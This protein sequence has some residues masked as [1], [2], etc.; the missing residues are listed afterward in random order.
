VEKVR[1]HSPVR[2][3]IRLNLGDCHTILAVHAERHLEH[4]RRRR[5]HGI[6]R[7]GV[8]RHDGRPLA[9]AKVTETVLRDPHDSMTHAVDP[10]A[11]NPFARLQARDYSPM[12]RQRQYQWLLVVVSTSTFH[13]PLPPRV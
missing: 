7:A 1:T 2:A 5:L 13:Q 6:F 4:I 11:A 10:R 12:P 9:V 8:P 3:L